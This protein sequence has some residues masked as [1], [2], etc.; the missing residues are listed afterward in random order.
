MKLTHRFLVA[1]LVAM[2]VSAVV[3]L[4]VYQT[5]SSPT[6]PLDQIMPEGALLYIEAKDFSGLM[7]DWNASPEKSQWLKSDDYRV[8][9]NS[10]LFLRLSKA[11]DEFAVA[12]GVPPN[13]KFL[14]DAA[15]KESALAIYN[16]GELEFLYVSRINNS[17]FLQSPLWQTRSKFQPRMA[18]GKSFYTR[19]DE[20][21]GR[22]VAFAVADD[23][24]ILGTREDLV[25][26]ALEHLTGNKTHTLKQD[27]WYTKALA[28]APSAAGDLRMAMHLEQIAVTPHFRTYWVQQNITEMQSYESAVSDLYREGTN[29]REERVILPGKVRDEDNSLGASAQ[30]VTGLLNMVPRDYGFYRAA[31][32]DAKSSLAVVEQKIIAPHFGAAPVEK[33]APQVQLGGGQTGSNSDMETR[34]DVEPASRTVT[35]NARVGLQKQFDAAGPQTMLVVQSTRKNSDGVLLGNPSVV[36]IAAQRDWD[37]AAVQKAIQDVVAPGLTAARM[38]VQWREVKDAGG[39][40]ELDGLSALQ[41]AARGKLLFF[42]NDA[43]ALSVVLQGKSS[44]VSPPVSYAAGFSHARER[45]NFY[46]LTGLVDRGSGSPDNEPQFFSRNIASFSRSFARVESE[47]VIARQTKDKIQQTVTYHWT[48]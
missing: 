23:Y 28:A 2:A 34:I 25:A 29:Y 18:G 48:Q 5:Q 42:A 9:S 22:E 31:Q 4:T 12:A 14:N 17:A 30:T 45:Q 11:S 15:G 47:E 26:G 13:M 41:V 24:L 33:L 44:V 32:T 27:G 35:E 46:D 6:R 7:K 38:G 43:G 3:G 37:L 40:F 21:S 36:V 8:F 19:K 10:R 1:A 16:I 39:Y 20:Q